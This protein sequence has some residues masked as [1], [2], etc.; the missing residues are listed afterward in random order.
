MKIFAIGMNYAEHNKELH[1][2]LLKP[3]EPVIFIKADSSLLK[4][5]KPFFIPDHL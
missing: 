3:E 2:T 4:N 1:G 5:G